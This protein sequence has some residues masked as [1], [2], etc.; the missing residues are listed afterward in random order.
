[1]EGKPFAPRVNEVS[2][3]YLLCFTGDEIAGVRD[4]KVTVFN[5]FNI[6][7]VTGNGSPDDR[8]L[9]QEFQ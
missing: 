3:C 5:A 9:G 4:K 6:A 7:V 1:M 8:M 2:E